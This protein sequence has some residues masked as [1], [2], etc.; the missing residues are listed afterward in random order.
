MKK[1]TVKVSVCSNELPECV[2]AILRWMHEHKI[3]HKH[4]VCR[5]DC[6]NAEGLELWCP[7]VARGC[8]EEYHIFEVEDSKVE[9]FE[10]NW[11]ATLTRTV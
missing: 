10:K 1:Y 2:H 6:Q 9:L 7:E 11:L 5:K 4:E 8:I 3:E